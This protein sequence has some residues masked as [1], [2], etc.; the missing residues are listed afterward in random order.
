VLAELAR[1][2]QVT[3]PTP[4]EAASNKLPIA[5][6]LNAAPA[7]RFRVAAPTPPPKAKLRAAAARRAPARQTVLAR[8][9]HPHTPPDPNDEKLLRQVRD[10]LIDTL[11]L[12][13]P[14][15]GARML[16]RTRNATSPHDMIDLVW[17]IEKNLSRSR[18]SRNEMISLQR[19]RE[20]LGLGN[21]LVA[22]DS[23]PERQE[24]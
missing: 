20:L 9:N 3:A 24:R 21:T 19:A 16:M 4:V 15:F 11:R 6:M 18:H 8:A 22:D 5:T 12:D 13:A 2:T 14:L 23:A 10:L 17:K 7:A 1:R